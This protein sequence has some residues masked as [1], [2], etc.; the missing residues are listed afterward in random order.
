MVVQGSE[1]HLGYFGNIMLH[2]RVHSVDIKLN[3][4]KY[5]CSQAWKERQIKS[6]ERKK[7]KGRRKKEKEEGKEERK[8][9]REGGGRK[10]G[11]NREGRYGERGRGRMK[12]RREVGK[13]GRN[14]WN[15]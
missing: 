7:W 6:E 1:T 11:R 4:F 2:D 8:G 9:K 15:S 5:V 10:E 3:N 14:H 12:E 13:R